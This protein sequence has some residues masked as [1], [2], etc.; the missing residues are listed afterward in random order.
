[1]VISIWA[2]RMVRQMIINAAFKTML[3]NTMDMVFVKNMN[4][5]Y[6]AASLQFVKMVGKERVEEILGKSDD[7]IFLNK[8]LAVRY[9]ADDRKL[10]AGGK[11][12]ENYIEPITDEDGHHRYGTTSKYILKDENDNP[13]GILGV[14]RDITRDYVS[15]QHYQQELSYLFEL[16]EDA[17]A[18][19]YID[20]DD[21]RVISQRRRMIHGSTLEAC[22][23]VEE[24]VGYAVSAIVDRK[25]EAAEFYCRFQP[26][27]LKDIYNIGR[28]D[29]SFKYQRCMPD[30]SI[31]W[32][33]NE[34]RFL[35][36]MDS[37]HLCAM[38][39]AKDIDAAKQEEEKLE[40]AAK[41]DQMTMLLNR[42]TTMEAIRG[43]LRRQS[44][45]T[46]ALF[47]LD[48]DNFKVLNDT[49]G[50]QAGDRYLVLLAEEIRKCFRD[51]DVKGR[52]GGDEFFVLM[53]NIQEISIV[54]KKA[55][56][57]LERIQAIGTEYPDVGL[58]G[59]IGISLYPC[60]G[61]T[62]EE[63]YAKADASLYQAKRSGKN[64]FIIVKE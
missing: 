50:H 59:S 3:D 11:N 60:N 48:M 40:V 56:L 30:G 28:R 36:D 32:V 2:I 52:I 19:A 46:H 24:L 18:V 26:D 8:D 51:S 38:L 4:L 55:I 9:V 29:I 22:H 64:K 61:S 15:R 27:M 16:P 12:L 57:L 39:S 25:S 33:K 1:M 44:G 20:I 42:E 37:G 31:R 54:Q 13:I 7:E 47:M 49:M 23:T 14:T 53:Q 62:V 58:T 34:I 6:V 10:L 17:Y 45:Q 41:M 35:D 43:I 5:E 21:W 63:L